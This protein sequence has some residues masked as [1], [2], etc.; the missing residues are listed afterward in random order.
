MENSTDVVGHVAG[1]M[2]WLHLPSKR[3][4]LICNA[5]DESAALPM[6]VNQPICHDR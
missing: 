5:F 1:D 4:S 6:E 2:H 3:T